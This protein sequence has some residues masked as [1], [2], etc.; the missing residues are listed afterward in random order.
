MSCW[1]FLP[2]HHLFVNTLLPGPLVLLFC[3]MCPRTV[4]SRGFNSAQGVPATL[5]SGFPLRDMQPAEEALVMCME[6]QGINM[7]LSSRYVPADVVPGMHV[8][9]QWEATIAT[10]SIEPFSDMSGG[11][12]LTIVP[13]SMLTTGSGTQKEAGQWRTW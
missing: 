8:K 13:R 3:L 1:A 4:F 10:M 12:V 7:V 2:E 11:S 6:S 9:R 5:K